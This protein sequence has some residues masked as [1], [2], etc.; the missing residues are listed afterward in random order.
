ML[1]ENRFS[2]QWK[3]VRRFRGVSIIEDHARLKSIS[4]GLRHEHVVQPQVRIPNRKSVTL[5][6]R[7]QRS[8]NV[9]VS[10]VFDVLDGI[11]LNVATAQ[12]DQPPNPCRHA[13][14]IEQFA[15]RQGVEV[16]DEYMK[17]VL[18]SLN[19]FKQRLD[20]SYPSSFAPLGKGRAEMKAEYSFLSSSE[21]NFEE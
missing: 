18:I 20:F 2:Q 14:H 5:V 3:M 7:V 13:T 6:V 1:I 16:S 17:T 21:N 15:G 10:R 19:T 12:P 9:D 4:E 8:V 11:A